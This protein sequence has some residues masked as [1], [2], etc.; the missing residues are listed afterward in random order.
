MY[1]MT[2]TA[3]SYFPVAVVKHPN[4]HMGGKFYLGLAAMEGGSVMAERHNCKKPQ[5]EA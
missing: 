4:Q 5:Q 2:T 3:L 1:S